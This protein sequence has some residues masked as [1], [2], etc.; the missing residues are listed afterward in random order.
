MKNWIIIAG[1]FVYV[2]IIIPCGYVDDSWWRCSFTTLR[3]SIN[4]VYCHHIRNLRCIC[5]RMRDVSVIVKKSKKIYPIVST[6][7]EYGFISYS[8]V[9][10]WVVFIPT[11][12]VLNTIPMSINIFTPIW[13]SIY[14][15]LMNPREDAQ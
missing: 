13:T 5:T 11:W 6:K 1:Q 10:S 3:V 15:N 7:I 14:Y 8:F 9:C 4:V 2:I 12:F